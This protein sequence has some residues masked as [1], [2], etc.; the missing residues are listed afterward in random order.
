MINDAQVARYDRE[1]IVFPIRVL[2]ETEAAGYLANADELQARMGDKSV[3][4]DT[5]TVHMHLPWAYELVTHTGMLDAVERVIGPNIV[6]W[7]CSLFAKRAHNP[8]WVSW[9]Q[10]GTYWNLESDRIVTAWLALSSST[11]DNGCMRVVPGSQKL[12]I[13]PHMDTFEDGNLLSRGQHVDVDVN[14]DDAVDVVLAPGEMSLHHTQLIHGSNPNRTDQA[15]IGFVTRYVT[16]QVRQ[17]GS[18]PL[19]VLARGRDDF[20]NYKFVGP[21]PT[22]RSLDD[23]VASLKQTAAEH[24]RSVM[25]KK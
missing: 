24:F 17:R 14:E 5:A 4:T 18:K 2:G 8:S 11:A 1:G 25:E 7:S 6:V 23:A 12:D 10:D 16:P 20:G 15:R 9:H 13:Q 19:A 22:D 21:P 3:P